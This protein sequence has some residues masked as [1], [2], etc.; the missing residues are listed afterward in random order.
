MTSKVTEGYRQ[1]H[2]SLDRLG[3]LSEI[4]NAGYTYFQTKSL[5]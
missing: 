5:K 2:P 3:F 1:C 4:G